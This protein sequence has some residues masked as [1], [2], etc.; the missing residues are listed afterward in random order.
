MEISSSWHLKREAFNLL[1][2]NAMKKAILLMSISLIHL[3]MLAQNFG[4]IQG[5]V[6]DQTGEAL[7]F[8]NVVAMQGTNPI[9]VSSD[10]NGKFKIKPLNPGIYD[11]EVS[12]IGYHKL[13]VNKVTV[14]PDNIRFMGDLVLSLNEVII[15]GEVCVIEY[16]DR[17]IDPEETGKMTMRSAEISQTPMA[18][19][20]VG[21]IASMA[22][23][24]YQKPGTNELYF[25]GSRTGSVLYMIDGQKV[26]NGAGNF[27]GGA[28]GSISVYTGGLPAKY[29]DT[30][31]GVVVI[32]TKN[33]FDFYNERNNRR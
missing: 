9:G 26:T 27:P 11:L 24:I 5:K 17:L 10:E 7:P 8:A 21:L 30:T 28:I 16:K 23:G 3:A 2:L 32:E 33:Y 20:P 12:F 29:G 6:V 1:I 22:P 13:V 19:N 4:E 15:E 31:G 25:K 14:N 18:K